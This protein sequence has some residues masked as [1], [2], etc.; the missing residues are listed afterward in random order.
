MSARNLPPLAAVRAFDA[1]A[2]HGTFT[3]AADELGMTQSAVSYQMKVLEE[4]V[5]APL[6]ERYARGVG[7]TDIGRRFHQRAAAAFDILSD[8]YGEAKCSTAGTLSLSVI[9]TFATNFLAQNLGAFHLKQPEIAV[10]MEISEALTDFT[11]DNVD[12]AIR[13]GQG[14]WEGLACH[15]LI[16]T[17]FTPMLSPELVER[18]GGV[19]TP[20]DLLKLPILSKDDAWLRIWLAADGV[21]NAPAEADIPRSFGP[22]VVEAGAAISGH[23]VGMLTPAF[24][25]NELERGQLVQPFETIGDDGSGYW[26]VYPESRRNAGKIRKFRSW[27]EQETRAFRVA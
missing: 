23:G 27:I 16:P 13:G 21:D 14:Q 15:L 22:Q 6:F 3:A 11:K 12:V 5:G 26:L 8:A 25:R 17:V 2:R 24:F 19:N 7:L 18:V 20:Q 1:A 9:P 10:R 4:R